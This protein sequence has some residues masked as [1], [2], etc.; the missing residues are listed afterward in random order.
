[1]YH[2]NMKALSK[3][4]HTTLSLLKSDFYENRNE[5]WVKRKIIFSPCS[6]SEDKE[7]N[8][9]SMKLSIQNYNQYLIVF[10]FN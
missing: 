2:K 3:I 5:I 4:Q 7:E 6:S 8:I 1:M 9:Q 10:S